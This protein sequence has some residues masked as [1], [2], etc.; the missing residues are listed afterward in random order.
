VEGI[1]RELHRRGWLHASEHRV[2]SENSDSEKEP[3]RVEAGADAIVDEQN[4][5]DCRGLV[6]ND[7][8]HGASEIPDRWQITNHT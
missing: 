8:P 5:F 3:H 7:A 6:Y 2:Q 4:I 1:S